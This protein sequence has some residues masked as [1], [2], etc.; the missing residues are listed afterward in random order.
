MSGS[1][2]PN[3]H[4]LAMLLQGA[5]RMREVMI[6]DHRAG[7]ALVQVETD[8]LRFNNEI[9]LHRASCPHCKTPEPAVVRPQ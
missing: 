8:L 5:Y 6:A 2:C 1:E 9:S 7:L 4:P 3:L